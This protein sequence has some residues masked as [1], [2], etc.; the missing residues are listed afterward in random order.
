M[1]TSRCILQSFVDGVDRPRKTRAAASNRP[2]VCED[3]SFWEISQKITARGKYETNRRI[4]RSNIGNSGGK[5]EQAGKRVT[6]TEMAGCYRGWAASG[7]R[8]R[9]CGS[10]NGRSPRNTVAWFGS[11]LTSHGAAGRIAVDFG[12]HCTRWRSYS[13]ARTARR[14]ISADEV[15]ADRVR[16][17]GS[18]AIR[19]H[20]ARTVAPS[21]AT[22]F[23]AD[24]SVHCRPGGVP[25]SS[26]P[27][28]ND[29]CIARHS[30]DPSPRH[31][32]GQVSTAARTV[33]S[34]YRRRRR[35][36]RPCAMSPTPA[37]SG[38]PTR[39]RSTA[40]SHDHDQRLVSST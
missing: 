23:C 28:T 26:H 13:P 3:V 20:P 4:G 12:G 18:S 24:A 37:G 32:M 5:A 33:P 29:W 19:P 35:R 22:S 40:R 15:T 6:K 7:V 16:W 17:S 9:A 39:R 11:P 27:P 25:A 34:P 10:D 38:Q 30:K 1:R 31:Q 21:T 14:R 36:R 2:L 8:V